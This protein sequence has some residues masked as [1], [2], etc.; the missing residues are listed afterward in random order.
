MSIHPRRALAESE[1]AAWLDLHSDWADGLGDPERRCLGDSRMSVVSSRARVSADAAAA[2][3]LESTSYAEREAGQWAGGASRAA[4]SASALGFSCWRDGWESRLQ[5]AAPPADSADADAILAWRQDVAP[6]PLLPTTSLTADHTPDHGDWWPAAYSHAQ[7]ASRQA[8]AAAFV[9]QPIRF[10]TD[11]RIVDVLPELIPDW[12]RRLLARPRQRL[13][14]TT[15]VFGD[16]SPVERLAA[17]QASVEH[18]STELVERRLS[19]EVTLTGDATWPSF[20]AAQSFGRPAPADTE[21]DHGAAA[22]EVD[23]A[24]WATEL[25][26]SELDAWCR[27]RLTQRQFEC[28]VSDDLGDATVRSTRRHAL[29]VLRQELPLHLRGL[30]RVAA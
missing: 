10:A 4:G 7:L 30:R 22:V 2:E 6:L 11:Y 23:E 26:A 16:L 15:W 13:T 24:D 3:Q 14:E 29:D 1:A 18:R 28:L 9:D 25:A 21:P 5:T 19:A 8:W 17:R 12:A 20:W 27:E